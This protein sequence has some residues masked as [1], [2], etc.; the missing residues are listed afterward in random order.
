MPS[1]LAWKEERGSS[2]LDAELT[3]S[4]AQAVFLTFFACVWV[5]FLVVWYT[6]A[7]GKRNVGPTDMV[8]WFPLIHVGVGF[9]VSYQALCGLLNHTRVSM[10][11]V[12]QPPVAQ[13]R[14]SVVPLRQGVRSGHG[15]TQSLHPGPAHV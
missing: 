4:R 3:P 7:L 15:R 13:T 1:D 11:P 14:V 12:S 6:T 2:G 5:G 8:V 10:S 9:F